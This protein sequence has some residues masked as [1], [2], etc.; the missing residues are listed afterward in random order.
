MTI[1]AV[2]VNTLPKDLGIEAVQRIAKLWQVDGNRVVWTEQG[3]DWWPGSFQ[4]S[5]KSQ[6]ITMSMKRLGG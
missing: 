2:G 4:V 1:K 5:V 6:N 3:F